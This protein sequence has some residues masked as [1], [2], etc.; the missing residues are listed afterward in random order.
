MKP[1]ITRTRLAFVGFTLIGGYF[2]LTEH[3][4]HIALALPYLPYLLILAC[5]LLHVFMH[6]GHGH[7]SHQDQGDVGSDVADN[8]PA[9][10]AGPAPEGKTRI[11]RSGGRHE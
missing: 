4:A 6:R 1:K 7:G 2:L 10:I 5:P 8:T 3:A 9:R 11:P